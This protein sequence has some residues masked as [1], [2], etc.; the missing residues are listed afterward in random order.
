MSYSTKSLILSPA[1]NS[2]TNANEL[3]AILPSVA[4]FENAEVS[5]ASLYIY[6]SWFNITQ[7]FN[8]TSFSYIWTDGVTYPVSMAEGYYSASDISGFMQFV[9]TQNGH[10]FVDVNTGNNVFYLEIVENPVYYSDSIIARPIPNSILPSTLLNPNN[11]ILNGQTPQLV[12]PANNNFGLL[13][14]YNQNTVYPPTPVFVPYSV[15]SSFTP[16]ISPVAT[17]SVVTNIANT[18]DLNQLQG[19]I[20]SFSS[21][22]YAFGQQIAVIPAYPVYYKVNDGR[23]PVISVSFLDDNNMPLAINDR[24]IIAT[25]SIRSKLK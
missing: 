16:K 7:K 14:G 4:Y 6:F 20:A 10:Y 3:T 1:N 2:S 8:N 9:M 25:L 12:I 19:V 13:L 5:L 11:I 21:G 17:V 22:N 23:V 24:Q 15:N 18:G